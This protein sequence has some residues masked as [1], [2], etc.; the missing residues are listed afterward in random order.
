MTNKTININGKDLPLVEP[1][2]VIITLKNIKTGEIYKNEE[3]IKAANLSPE[4]VQRDVL[5]KM[6]TLDL[7]GKTK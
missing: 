7:F 3:A 6:P 4:E 1:T 2:E 5:V